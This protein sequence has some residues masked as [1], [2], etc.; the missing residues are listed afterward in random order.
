MMGILLLTNSLANSLEYFEFKDGTRINKSL[1][2]NPFCLHV[3]KIRLN[4]DLELETTTIEFMGHQ[5]ILDVKQAEQI[6]Q[7]EQLDQHHQK[8]KISKRMIDYF[9][10]FTNFLTIFKSVVHNSSL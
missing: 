3:F 10:E 1:K 8:Y 5:V 6:E 7:M 9:S 2:V 4:I